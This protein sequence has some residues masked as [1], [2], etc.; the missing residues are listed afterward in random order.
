MTDEIT[1]Y[2]DNRKHYAPPE[3]YWQKL[4]D[5]PHTSYGRIAI[6]LNGNA[7]AILTSSV[8]D[9]TCEVCLTVIQKKGIK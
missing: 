4:R 3:D 9:T 7:H 6:C 8:E 5:R 1:Y 2:E